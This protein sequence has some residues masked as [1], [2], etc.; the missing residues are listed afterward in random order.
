MPSQPRPDRRPS[1]TMPWRLD[2]TRSTSCQ[3]RR[4]AGSALDGRAQVVAPGADRVG[5]GLQVGLVD[6][7]D[8]V[9]QARDAPEAL[10]QAAAAPVSPAPRMSGSTPDV[11]AAGTAEVL[12]K[13]PAAGRRGRDAAMEVGEEPDGPRGRRRAA[14]SGRSS[15]PGSP[16]RSV[17]P[18]NLVT[19][20][21]QPCRPGR[22][23][24]R[25]RRA[26]RR[27]ATCGWGSRDRSRPGRA[28]RRPRGGR[29]TSR[30]SS[31]AGRAARAPRCGRAAPAAR[32]LA[33]EPP[34]PLVDGDRPQPTPPVARAQLPGRGEPRHATPEDHDPGQL[35]LSGARRSSAATV[36]L[37]GR[38]PAGGPSSPPRA[39]CASPHP[40]SRQAREPGRRPLAGGRPGLP[41]ASRRAPPPAGRRPPARDPRRRRAVYR[42]RCRSSSG[43]W[44]YSPVFSTTCRASPTHSRARGTSPAAACSSARYPR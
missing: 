34:A 13:M 11:D 5:D 2:A 4:S 25:P 1:T 17:F 28:R 30:R 14:S 16:G 18:E 9:G 31:R 21:F 20:G 33:A 6:P 42:A 27:P 44:R 24:R 43:R 32:A 39:R 10:E 7:G 12:R 26:R 41:G 15:A 19:K 36:S 23:G 40:R 29:G 3:V 8:A 35:H 22:R 37:R 38:R